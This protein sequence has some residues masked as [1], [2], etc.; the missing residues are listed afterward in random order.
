MRKR[1]IF[2]ELMEGVAAMKGPRRQDHFA[3]VQSRSLAAAQG[4]LEAHP[5]HAEETALLARGFCAPAPHQR[6]DAGKM[7]TGPRE[8]ESAGGGVGAAGAA[9]SGHAGTTG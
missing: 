2:A 7:G 6:T 9:V 1:D 5:G 3:D 8:T 4:R